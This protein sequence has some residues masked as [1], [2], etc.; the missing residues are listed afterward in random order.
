MKW[1]P[2]AKE[3]EPKKPTLDSIKEFQMKN[4][5][6]IAIFQ[7]ERGKKPDL[8]IV[9][10]FQ[11]LKYSKR[12]RT[13]K[14]IHWAID[15]L[16]KREHEPELTNRFIAY[17]RDMWDKIEPFKSKTDQQKCE[18]KLT[19]HEKLKE[20]EKLDNFGELSVEF[21]GHVI[22]LF[23]IEEKTGFEGAFMFKDLF[24]ALYE[25]KDIFSIISLATYNGR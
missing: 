22:E 14:H 19:S 24:D 5:V 3:G 15:L 6:V 7:G 18:L 4:K 13:P 23:M 1:T 12:I 9:V 2:K 17:L 20:Y 25:G 10:K 21:I 16:I 8:D 11:D